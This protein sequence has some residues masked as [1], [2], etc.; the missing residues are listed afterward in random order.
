MAY[1]LLCLYT[2]FFYLIRLLSPFPSSSVFF[3][4]CVAFV[5][6]ALV[7]LPGLYCAAYRTAFLAQPADEDVFLALR[8]SCGC[9]R[10]LVSEC[11]FLFVTLCLFSLLFFLRTCSR[12]D[13]VW[14]R[15]SCGMD[16]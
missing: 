16:S 10:V 14:F 8:V 15:L 2:P 4:R 11:T 6:L 1:I 9:L 3:F 12:F 13:L 5:V 7:F